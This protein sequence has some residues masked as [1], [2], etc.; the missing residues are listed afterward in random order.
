[1][2]QGREM[3]KNS[4]HTHPSIAVL[5]PCYNEEKTIAKVIKD[6]HHEL[7]EADIY[8]YDNNSS[9]KSAELARENGAVVIKEKRQGK[10]YVIMSMF[11]D[12]VAD[13]YVMVDGD[14]T[15]PASSVHDLLAPV[16]NEEADMVVGQRLTSYSQGAFPPLHFL[17]N[18]LVC[19]LVNSVFAT[20]LKDP[21]S[22]YRAFNRIVTMQCP[23]VATGFDVETEMTLQML[24]RHMKIT[25]VEV[26][27]RERPEGSYS[28]LKTFSDGLKVFYKI[29]SI[30][31]SYKPLTFF[32]GISLVLAVIGLIVGSFVIREYLLYQYI[33]SVPKAVLATGLIIVAGILL[34]IGII[35]HV[36]NFRLLEESSNT[37]KMF[38]L[39]DRKFRE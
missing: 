2:V 12:I 9:D 36:L 25:E 27:Y 18:K 11:N 30:I 26:S 38:R 34:A 21:M 13:F 8:V 17:G 3:T 31:P 14:D 16:L 1:M 5:I 10:G 32:G 7:P 4:N 22:G 29:F 19:S 28:K 39:L 20:K 37:Q 33:Y 24:Y 6:F 35:L 15:Y 23:V